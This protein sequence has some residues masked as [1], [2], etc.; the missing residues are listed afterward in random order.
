MPFVRFKRR[1]SRTYGY[2]VENRWVAKAGQ[3]R[4]HVL[5][6]LGPADQIRLS[7]LPKAVRTPALSARLKQATE[8]AEARRTA[9]FRNFHEELRE[10]LRSGNFPKARGTALRALR[11]I[12]LGQLYG[13]L[14]PEV[15]KDIGERWAAGSLSISQEHLASGL[16]ARIVEHVNTRVRPVASL[17]QEVVLCVPEGESHA[18]ALQLGEGLLLQRGFTPLN[19][20]ASAPLSSTLSFVREREPVAVFVSVTVPSNLGAARTL[21]LQVRRRAP[22]VSVIIGGQAVLSRPERAPEDG[23]EYVPDSLSSFLE[24]WSPQGA[25]RSRK[26]VARP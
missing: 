5:R 17:G 1:R 3:P 24:R 16:A 11:E 6:Y 18:L 9:A 2:L 15:F 20:G 19:V 12:G 22:G 7:E 21:A 8:S 23:I 26:R 4:Q 13:E 14:I 25:P 10:S